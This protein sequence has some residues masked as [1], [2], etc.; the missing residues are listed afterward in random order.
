MVTAELFLAALE[1][2]V[3][4]WYGLVELLHQTVARRQVAH[5]SER[6]GMVGSQFCPHYRQRFLMERQ[7][8]FELACVAILRP[9]VVHADER[10]G[11]IVTQFRFPQ[12]QRL[13]IE[14]Q[15]LV[16]LMRVMITLSQA[17]H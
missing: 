8:L 13:L 4:H 5:S 1:Q 16:E 11:M 12:S 15:R 2:L 10:V 6:V 14:R 9:Q 17:V 3:I 7:R